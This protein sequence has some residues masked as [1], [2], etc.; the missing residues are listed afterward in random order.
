MMPCRR[1]YQRYAIKILDDWNVQFSIWICKRI[2]CSRAFCNL[3]ISV[4][5]FQN[6]QKL[7]RNDNEILLFLLN[8]R[9]FLTIKNTFKHRLTFVLDPRWQ[10]ITLTFNLLCHASSFSVNANVGRLMR[11]TRNCFQCAPFAVCTG[12]CHF[13][14]VWFT[15]NR[16]HFSSL[17]FYDDWEVDQ[18]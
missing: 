17:A 3:A 6:I 16:R 12:I 1:R 9:R 14:I 5:S 18:S 11:I 8:F 7:G 13:D 10:L 2:N 4:Q 15:R